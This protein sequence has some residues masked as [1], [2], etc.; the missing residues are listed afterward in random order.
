MNNAFV[1]I[2]LS[3]YTLILSDVCVTSKEF[4]RN[5]VSSAGENKA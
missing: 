4:P 1:S 2:D 3:F 5:N